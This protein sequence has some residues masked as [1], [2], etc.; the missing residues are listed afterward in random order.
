MVQ[1]EEVTVCHSLFEPDQQ[2]QSCFHEHRD[3][4][5]DEFGIVFTLQLTKSI[6]YGSVEHSHLRT[7]SLE[8][9]PDHQLHL[10]DVAELIRSARDG[11]KL[12]DLGADLVEF[13]KKSVYS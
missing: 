7:G 6:E 10:A 4:A 1:R 2:N 5:N 3:H 12:D 11:L 9:V 13:A 8:C